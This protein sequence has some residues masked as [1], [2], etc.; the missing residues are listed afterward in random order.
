MMR[1]SDPSQTQLLNEVELLLQQLPL[2]GAHLLEL[3]CG[4][5]EK[6]RTLAQSQRLAH[7]T[8]V[9]I[10]PIQHARHLTITDLPQ[11]RFMRGV[12]QEIPLADNSVDI[13]VMFKSLHH[14]PL[15]A[16]DTA[17]TEIARVLKPG[18]L[19]WISEPVFAGALNE[20]MRLF[21]DEEVVR[22]AA[23]TAVRRAVETHVLRLKQQFFF[24]TRSHFAD[25]AAFEQRM[26]G[27]THTHHQLSLSQHAAVKEKF[28]Q[29]LGE[30]GAT[31]H[32]PQRVDFLQ[33]PAI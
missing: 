25:F 4:N 21:N 12:A 1:L 33:K 26:I 31:F 24:H 23:F 11:V 20:V 17:L 9:E 14:V 5:A 2:D 7:I 10:D 16:M 13:V 18:G 15:E 28:C 19:A 27:V 29:Y 8:A 32:N 30:Q 22:Q 3:G 6:T